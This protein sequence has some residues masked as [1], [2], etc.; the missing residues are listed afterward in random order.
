MDGLVSLQVK[1]MWAATDYAKR[2]I[3]M[4]Y[5]WGGND[6]HDGGLDCSGFVLEVLRSVGLWGKEDASAQ[7]IFNTL[8]NSCTIPDSP[9]KGDLAFFGAS[10]MK[11]THV[12]LMDNEWQVIEFG[13]GGRD[14]KSGMGRVRP[15][16]AR[17]DLVA[18]LRFK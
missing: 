12:A 16:E 2:F 6:A 15:L 17:N 9:Q 3:G 14:S 7:Q 8:A 11:I 5:I 13:G 18:I 10:R 4:K 1:K